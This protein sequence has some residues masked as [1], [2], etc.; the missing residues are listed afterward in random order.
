MG[1]AGQAPAAAT[2]CLVCELK[3][4][5]EEESKDELEKRLGMAQERKVGRLIVEVDGNGAVLTGRFGGLSHGLPSV[6]MAVGV[7]EPS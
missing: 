6:E 3:A 7:E 1:V 4:D 2:G 5:R